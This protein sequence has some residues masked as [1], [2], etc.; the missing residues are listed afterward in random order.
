[1]SPAIPINFF[2]D[3]WTAD[4][5]SA[6]SVALRV[7][8][9]MQSQGLKLQLARNVWK[10]DSGLRELVQAVYRALKTPDTSQPPPSQERVHEVLQTLNNLYRT[11]EQL[12]ADARRNGLTN[13]TFVGAA[14]N[15][16]HVRAE[17]ILDII[18]LIEVA[19]L[20]TENHNRAFN[21]SLDELRRGEVF[22]LADIT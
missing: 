5:Y 12:H 17:E 10:L 8:A 4:L 18:D 3:A 15:S 11:V 14:Y 1:M 19:L 13:N 22:D 2:G 7:S 9:A 21:E 16:A 6:T 20:P